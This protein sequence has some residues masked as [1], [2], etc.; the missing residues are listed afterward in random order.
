MLHVDATLKLVG[1][2]V[3]QPVTGVDP[4]YVANL[5]NPQASPP[6]S[7]LPD[8]VTVH[9]YGGDNTTSDY[10]LFSD[11]V[12]NEDGLAWI[13]DSI[14]Q[15]QASLAHAGHA[16]T[17]LWLDETN[18]N[19]D[20]G[21][22][23][24]SREWTGFGA[25]WIGAEYIGL[26]K[27]D[28]SSPMTMLPFE[29]VSPQDDQSLVDENTGAALL[30]YWRDF[31]LSHRFQTGANV[32]TV[33]NSTQVQA[34][35]TRDPS[36]GLVDLLLVNSQAGG[37]SSTIGGP[38]TPTTVTVGVG[39]MPSISSVTLWVFDDSIV[40]G[41]ANGDLTSGP[42]PQKLASHDTATVAFVGYGIAVVEFAP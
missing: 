41:G 33:T 6:L 18:V 3:S 42:T 40:T 12:A 27:L 14:S 9:G 32:V 2:A 25:A 20:T 4:E 35:A 39:G 23:T 22:G 7:H 11:S 24:N 29:L 19:Y 15:I 10:D 36:S 8:V 31:A 1:P 26:A 38:G 16:N 37:S 28:A 34:L 21:M 13:L 5:F 17:P 30:S